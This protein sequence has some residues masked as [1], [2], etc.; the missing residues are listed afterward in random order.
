MES[1][2]KA[3]VLQMSELFI[4][5]D[6]SNGCD[7]SSTQ[8]HG[9]VDVIMTPTLDRLEKELKAVYG[10]DIQHFQDN[11]YEVSTVEVNGGIPV[12]IMYSIFIEE[13]IEQ[14]VTTAFKNN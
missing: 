3:Q 14:P 7:P 2:F 12:H 9:I 8:D 4:D 13:V 6:E 11:Q 1:N 10:E 5:N